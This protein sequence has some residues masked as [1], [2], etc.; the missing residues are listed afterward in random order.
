MIC[1][2][3][4]PVPGLNIDNLNVEDIPI[5]RKIPIQSYLNGVFDKIEPVQL[6]K[7]NETVIVKT[8]DEAKKL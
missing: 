1:T 2:K 4:N 5:K 8:D 6:G 3:K 7:L